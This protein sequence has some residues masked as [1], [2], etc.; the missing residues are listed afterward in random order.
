MVIVEI[1]RIL[2]WDLP[3]EKGCSLC[4]DSIHGINTK[5][6]SF[7][8]FRIMPV[9]YKSR[10]RFQL[11]FHTFFNE[12]E[13]GMFTAHLSHREDEKA[14]SEMEQLQKCTYTLK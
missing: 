11:S 6:K 5:P 14:R 2:F 3:V 4:S 9:Q 1:F 12:V 8:E 10:S 7:R 13:S